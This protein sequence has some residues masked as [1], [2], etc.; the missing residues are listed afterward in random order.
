MSLIV[1]IF[2]ILEL[3]NHLSEN[4]YVINYVNCINQFYCSKKLQTH[5]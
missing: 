2:N 1:C 5:H 3:N 4:I